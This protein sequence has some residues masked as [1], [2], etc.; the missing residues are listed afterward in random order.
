MN[1]LGRVVLPFVPED[2]WERYAENMYRML[3]LRKAPNPDYRGRCALCREVGVLF[4]DVKFYWFEIPRNFVC[5]T[6]YDEMPEEEKHRRWVDGQIRRLRQR[7]R[8]LC[9]DAHGK[10]RRG[11]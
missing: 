11:P 10:K 1:P 6:C 8:R 9:R 5:N 4:R 2:F 7:E 3:T